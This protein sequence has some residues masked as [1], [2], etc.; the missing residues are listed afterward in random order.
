[1][2]S[3]QLEAFQRDKLFVSVYDSL[4]HRKTAQTDATELTDTILGELNPLMTDATISTQQIVQVTIRVL[5]RFDTAAATYY[6]A[7]HQR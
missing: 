3:E 1:M 6:Q 4:K 7:F 2:T 5:Q